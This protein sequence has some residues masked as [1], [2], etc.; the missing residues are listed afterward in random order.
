[1]S[2]VLDCGDNSCHFSPKENRGGMRTNGGCRCFIN[3]GYKST[4]DAA[5]KMLPELLEVKTKLYDLKAK[6]REVP[7]T[8]TEKHEF[9]GGLVMLGKT[10]F[11]F[12]AGLEI[13]IQWA[14]QQIKDRKI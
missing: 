10:D 5:Y 13:G 6:L 8:E 4:I 11:N 7:W 3:L 1:M 14:A 12:L 2:V 9:R